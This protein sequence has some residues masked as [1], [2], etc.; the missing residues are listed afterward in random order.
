MSDVTGGAV[1]EYGSESVLD[2]LVD[3]VESS[4]VQGQYIPETQ[5]WSHR[6][7]AASSPVKHHQEM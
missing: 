5:S 3:H 2:I 4:E 1:A 6:S 7:Q